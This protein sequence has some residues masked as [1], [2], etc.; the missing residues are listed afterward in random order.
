MKYN[1]FFI[2]AS[3]RWLSHPSPPN[4]QNTTTPKLLEEG[5][6]N[7]DAMFTTSHVSGEYIFWDKLIELVGEGSVINA[8]FLVQ[9]RPV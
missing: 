3:L 8:A 9:L 6:W 7:F 5:N 4:I 1:I 2:G